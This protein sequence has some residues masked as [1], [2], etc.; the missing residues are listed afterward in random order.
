ME[1]GKPRVLFVVP[2]TPAGPTT[3][4]IRND[5]AAIER[6]GVIGNTFTLSSRS[7][8]PILINESRR[9]RREVK[10]FKPDLI[11][12]HYGT[13]TAFFSAMLTR[14]PLVITYQG[15]DLN[16]FWHSNPLRSPTGR[17]LSQLAALRAGRIICVSEKLRR[18]LWWKRARASVLP[19]GVDTAIFHPISKSEAR[20]KLGW[21]QQ[22]K[23]VV[24]S[25]GT[26]PPRKR[27]DLAQ[28]SIRAA[29]SLCG[30]IR[31]VVLDGR[32][33]HRDVPIIFNASDCFLMTSDSEGSP[34]VV[35]ES[36]ACGLPVVSVDVG[37]VRE[38]LRNVR[39]S[40]I[41]S[42]DPEAIG[43]AL[44]EILLESERSNGPQIIQD[45]STDKIAWRTLR[46]YEEAL[47][48]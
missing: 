43:K 19:S 34:N 36:I 23:I 46:L 45:L 41:V 18:R 39:P 31:F 47:K 1:S 6:C 37:D 44:A 16:H 27:L 13:V 35:K 40:A 48:Q 7:S 38:R 17:V 5:I 22:E 8:L 3:V 30:A 10:R 2:G 28:A 24:S 9:F 15:S 12:A 33:E 11:H 26:D 42:R 21:G 14:K 32:T 20:T 4:F 25:A 29:E